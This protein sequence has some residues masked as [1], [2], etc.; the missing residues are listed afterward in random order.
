LNSPLKDKRILITGA[1]G[2][3]GAN[4]VHYALSKG[5]CVSIFT[6]KGSNRWRIDS[7]LSDLREY[8][9]DLLNEVRVVDAVAQ[10]KPEIIFHTAVYGGYP[11]QNHLRRILETNIVGTVNLLTACRKID[12]ELFINTGSSSEY[13][14]KPAPMKEDDALKPLT[15]YGVSKASATLYCQAISLG[16]ARPIVTLRLFSPYGY[17]E[18]S[19]RLIP[20]VILSYLRGENAGVSLP[21]SVRDFVFIEDVVDAYVKAVENSRK[22]VGQ[23]FNVGYGK[24]HTV[25][26][27]VTEIIEL[28]GATVK[29]QWNTVGNPRIEPEFWQADI[30]KI[31]RLL[32][33]QP[34]HQ[35]VAGL[36]K[37]TA[38]FGE[39]FQLYENRRIC[40]S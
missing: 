22:L 37:T 23:I 32:D 12:F 31:E 28:T 38:W 4:L 25:S 14:V 9:V 5:A 40:A 8:C 11:S 13:G 15:P 7:V 6:R 34:Q 26:D 10:I 18:E 33:W 21:D 27:V 2:F 30:S 17:Y 19:T 39:N 29:P 20:S 16:Q 1:T 35:L 36:E 24:Q 3:I